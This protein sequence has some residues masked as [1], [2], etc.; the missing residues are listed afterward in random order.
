MGAPRRSFRRRRRRACAR[1][2][3]AGC[4][5]G[6]ARPPPDGARRGG[7]VDCREQLP[8]RRARSP[9]TS[10]PTTRSSG[11]S[12]AT[13]DIEVGLVVYCAGADPNYEPFLS[14]P[15]DDALAMLR[16]NCAVPVQLCHHFG[17]LMAAR[18]RGGI[19]LVGSGAGLVG[20]PNM[21]AYAA[22]KAF[23]MVL[24]E[25]LWSELHDHGVDVLGL[26]LGVTDTPALRRLLAQRGL[27]ASPDDDS[28]IPGCGERG[29]RGRGSTGEPRERTDLVR[30]RHAPRGR[31][32]A[33]RLAAQR[34]RALDGARWP[35]AR[36]A[37]ARRS[38]DDRD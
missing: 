37:R 7:R 17:G 13:S 14:Q 9:S 26:I 18:G 22:T 2:R 3:G 24:A 10:P 21:V 27:L 12:S 32:A 1:A 38:S 19:V 23:D 11:S 8:R 34:R 33:P 36:W 15:V 5:R 30:R 20:A 4:Q 16:R 28:P 25:S 29:G 6:V 31:A 35:A